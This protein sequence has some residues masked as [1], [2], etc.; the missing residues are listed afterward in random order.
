[1]G[2]A[3]LRGRVL[4]KPRPPDGLT[5]S[6]LPH[7][8]TAHFTLSGAV[9]RQE[10]GGLGGAPLAAPHLLLLRLDSTL[11]KRVR[12]GGAQGMWG[13]NEGTKGDTR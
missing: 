13:D 4:T 2:V 8:P 6:H 5:V 1:M 12:P 10:V 11:G 7:G 9:L 3:C